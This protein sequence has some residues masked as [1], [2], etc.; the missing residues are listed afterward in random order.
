M[1][2][3]EYADTSEPNGKDE[4]IWTYD[5]DLLSTRSP[6]SDDKRKDDEKRDEIPI[7][8]GTSG[9]L[10]KKIEGV[11]HELKRDHSHIDNQ[12]AQPYSKLRSVPEKTDRN[13]AHKRV[14]LTDSWVDDGEPLPIMSFKHKKGIEN[15]K[16]ELFGSIEH[17]TI[18]DLNE[19]EKS[20]PLTVKQE[21]ECDRNVSDTKERIP[22][23]SI[24]DLNDEGK[25]WPH[26]FQCCIIFGET[27]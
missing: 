17:A 16:G 15:N 12:V 3:Q 8:S 1:G 24:M 6:V 27:V 13:L 7:F 11:T 9:I 21:K 23:P 10:H 20:P 4:M 18:I 5:S 14:A 26:C 22:F 2:D 19:S 25:H